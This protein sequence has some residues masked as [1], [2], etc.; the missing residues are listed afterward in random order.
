MALRYR[1]L[2]IIAA[3]LALAVVSLGLVLSYDSACAN[4]D[5]SP[6]ATMR[7]VVARCYGS[8]DVLNIEEVPKPTLPEDRLL[9]RVHAAALNPLDLHYMTGTP[10]VMRLSAGIGK[11]SDTRVGVDFAGTVEAVGKN[12]SRFKPGDQV[13]GGASGAFAEYVTVREQGTVA[14][15]PTNVTF[16]QAGAVAIAGVTALQALRDHGQVQPGQRVL[17]NGASGGVGTFA[18][19]IAKSM[20]AEVTGVCST[21]N[22]ELVRSLGADHVIDYTQENFTES[23]KTYDVILDN[24]GNHPLSALRRVLTPQGTLVIVGGPKNDPWIG[25]LAGRIKASLVAPFVEQKLASF[26]AQLTQKD[27]DA[28]GKLMEEGKVTTVID[29]RFALDE[30]REAMRYL[31]TGRARG[32]VVVVLED[33]PI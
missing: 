29:R 7:A 11:P 17:I 21:R 5:S 19:Q 31:Q 2:G 3:V 10:Y 8:V 6:A 18:V 16:E 13:F 26:F 32:K 33:T 25:P 27:L 12:V 9:V 22:V 28:L 23:G 1:I 24:V 20:G 14:I 15:K 4:A 30:V